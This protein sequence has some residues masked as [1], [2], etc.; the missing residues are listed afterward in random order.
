MSEETFRTPER[1]AIPITEMRLRAMVSP[2]NRLAIG[3]GISGSAWW[4]VGVPPGVL[5]VPAGDQLLHENTL[6]F[7]GL[8]GVVEVRF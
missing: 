1:V 8:M 3:A 5:P 4:D 6:V 2:F 7:F